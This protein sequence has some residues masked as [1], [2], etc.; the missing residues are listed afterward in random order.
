MDFIGYISYWLTNE[1]DQ[2]W[3]QMAAV[4]EGL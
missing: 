4:L 2:H 3:R 1:F